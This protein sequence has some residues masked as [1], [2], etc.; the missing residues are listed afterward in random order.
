[1]PGS[2]S[3][4]GLAASAEQVLVWRASGRGC[5]SAPSPLSPSSPLP[6]TAVMKITR[7]V[8]ER[9]SSPS[10][11]S[12]PCSRRWVGGRA[13]CARA[14]LPAPFPKVPRVRL[15]DSPVACLPPGAQ[16]S[17]AHAPARERGLRREKWEGEVE[18]RPF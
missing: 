5:S 10:G 1:M 15:G 8:T 16:Y 11:S 4:S 6:E 18:A 3:S 13:H 2:G 9:T 17:P 7:L 12:R 14:C